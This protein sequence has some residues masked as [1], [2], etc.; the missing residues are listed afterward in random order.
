MVGGESR[1]A[2]VKYGEVNRI[3][4][5]E[6]S[7]PFSG[8]ESGG[9]QTLRAMESKLEDKAFVG[10]WGQNWTQLVQFKRGA[11]RSWSATP[12]GESDDPASPHYCDQ[13]DKLFS[14]DRLKPTWFQPGDLE[15]NVE[16][17]RVLHRGTQ[18]EQR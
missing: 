6:H 8:G 2:E 9:G 10:H 18:P 11:V 15:G 16:S 17:T 3:R 5:G 4:R 7:W 14:Q 12:Y 1:D 13:A